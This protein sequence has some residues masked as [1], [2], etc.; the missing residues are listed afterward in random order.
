MSSD[1]QEASPDQQRGAIHEGAKK[2]N[3]L[4]I[5]EY[6]DDAI[7]GDKTEKRQAFQQMIR[8]A[9]DRGDFREIWCWDQDRFGRFDSLEAGYWIWPLRNAGVKL[10]TIAQGAIDWDDFAG[11]MIYGIQQEAKHAFLRDLSRNVC[12]GMRD[13]ALA[14]KMVVPCYGYNVVDGCY[15]PDPVTAPVVRRI[16]RLYVHN[17]LSYRGIIRLLNSEGIPAPNGGN[18]RPSEI[19]RILT[20]RKYTGT[21]T[22]GETHDGTYHSAMADGIVTRA[23]AD[24]VVFGQGIVIPDHHEAIVDVATFDAAARKIAENKGRTSPFG[25]GS[26]FLLTG[27]LWCAECGGRMTGQRDSR[28]GETYVCSTYYMLGKAKCSRNRVMAGP[29][30]ATILEKL[31][32]EL[33]APE[34]IQALRDEIRRQDEAARTPIDAKEPDRLR[35]RLA[36]LDKQIDQGAER[37]L[38]APASIAQTLYAK[39]ESLQDERQETQSRLTALEASRTAGGGNLDKDTE[40]AL[41]GLWALRDS[42]AHAQKATQGDLLREAVSRVDL[43]FRSFARGT[44]TR[45]EFTRGEITPRWDP[46]L[47]CSLFHPVTRSN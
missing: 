3:R 30:V 13:S 14:G 22:W 16:F 15:I 8:D 23:K 5:R 47:P 26:P 44:Q 33:L 4:I 45:S 42:F 41:A 40:D 17:G 24:P 46:R 35:R 21:F 38:S 43:H 25:S 10:V 34:A 28:V 29:L 31:Q 37:C 36:N 18:W 7:S 9:A 1:K 12:R 6:F 2:Q 39:L 11:R 32:T 19:S 20:R 27:L